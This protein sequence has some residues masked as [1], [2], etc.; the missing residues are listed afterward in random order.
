VSY[1]LTKLAPGSY[2][3]WRNGE[4]IASLVR[5]GQTSD[6]TWT[7]ELLVEPTTGEM[8]APFTAPEQLGGGEP[9]ARSPCPRLR[10]RSIQGDLAHALHRNL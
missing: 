7:A 9:L 1:K 6:A 5:S 2:D 3:V 10:T 8:P 4:I